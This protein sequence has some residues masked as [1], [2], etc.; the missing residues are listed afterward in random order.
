MGKQK[1]LNKFLSDCVVFDV[2][3]VVFSIDFIQTPGTRPS[4]AS[5]LSLTN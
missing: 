4:A 2:Q 3:V 1:N 5:A